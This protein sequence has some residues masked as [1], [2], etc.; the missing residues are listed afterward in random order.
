MIFSLLVLIIIIV[1]GVIYEKTRNPKDLRWD[2]EDNLAYYSFGGGFA[3]AFAL[4]M[5]LV[6]QPSLATNENS[7]WKEKER[8]EI[9]SI[10][11]QVGVEGHFVLGSGSIESEMYYFYYVEG[12]NGGIVINKCESKNVEIVEKDIDKGYIVNYERRYN[13]PHWFF[14]FGT[15]IGDEK[16]MIEVPKGTIKYNYNVSLG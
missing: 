2:D 15:F 10:G 9:Y 12:S 1:I 11:N 13:K 3:A 7:Y 5:F 16:V 6:G 8:T 14:G 4:V